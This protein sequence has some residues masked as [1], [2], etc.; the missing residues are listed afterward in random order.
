MKKAGHVLTSL[1]LLLIFGGSPLF[2]QIGIQPP[3]PPR[4]VQIFEPAT[5]PLG[6][7]IADSVFKNLRSKSFVR[8]VKLD[9][10]GQYVS[11]REAIDGREFRLPQVV[12]IETYIELRLRHDRQVQ[13]AQAFA[14]LIT[15]QVEQGFGALELEIPLRI[16]SQTFNRIFGSD[17]I[18]MRV[19]GNITFDLSGRTEKRSGSAVSALEDRGTFSP[20]FR[21]TQQFTVE[22]KIG[23]KVTVSVE[24]NSEAVS[25]V[26]NTLKLRYDG[27]EDEIVQ[28]IEAGNISLSLPSTKYVIFG[29]SN[30]GLFG[31]KAQMQMGNL[32]L[33]TIASLEKGQQEELTVNGSASEQTHTIKDYEFIRNRYFFIDL[34]YHGYFEQGFS[35]DLQQFNFRQGTD[36][37]FLD[38]YKTVYTTN[39]KVNSRFGIA[40]LDPQNYA[41]LTPSDMD[42]VIE[43]DGKTAKGYFRRLE[44]NVDYTFDKYRGF[45]AL[46]QSIGS[47]EVLAVAF[48]T[49]QDVARG[50]SVGTL[51]ASLA[52]SAQPVILK[53]IKPKNLQPNTT[54][55]ETW[56]LMMKN[57]YS[58]GG[59]NIEKD[60]FELKLEYN[61]TENHERFPA[62]GTKSFLNLTGL[63]VTDANGAP[64]D[65]GDD[66][67]DFN[68]YILNFAQ[69]VMIFPSLQPFNPGSAGKFGEFAA[70]DPKYLVNIYDESNETTIR[71]RSR[72]VMLVTS[73]STKSTFDLGFY[74]LEGS[75]VVTL[76]GQTLDRDKD[77]LIDYFSGQLTLLSPEAKRQSASL[78][79][80]YER[81]NLFQLDKKTIVG[82]RLEYR[83]WENSFVGMTG[84]YL[85]KTTLDERVRVGQEP[86][87]NFVWDLNGA[88][89]F[90]PRF[91]T[92]ALDA[93]PLIETNA[94]SQF[95]IE[96]E[97]AQVLP[98]PNTLNS[99]TTGDN[100]GVAY[101]DD[102]ESSKRTTTLGIRY[103]T[104]T[105]ASTPVKMSINGSDQKITDLEGDKTR[106]YLAWFNPYFQVPIK[107][108]W[109]NRDVNS[110]TGQTTEVLGLE[111]ARAA[112]SDPDS[113]W[114]GVMRTT[115][116]FADQQKTKYIEL[117]V[118]G[119][120]GRLNIDIGKI[121][122]DWWIKGEN[123]KNEPSRGNLNEEDFV[124]DNDLLDDGEDVGI[125]GIADGQ[126]GDDDKD[127]WGTPKE[128]AVNRYDGYDYSR[129]NG[130]EGNGDSRE[131][132][133][134]DTE[135]LDG[136][137]SLNV[138]NEYFE[139]SFSLDSLNAES[140]Q[141][142]A[143]ETEKGWRLFRIPLSDFTR[144]IGQPDTNFQQILA[145]RLW[146]SELPVDTTRIY[147]ATLD[148][149]G[150]EWE[151]KGFAANDSSAFILNDDVFSLATNNTEENAV[152]VEGLEPYTPPPGVSGTRDRITNTVSKEQSLV[153][154]FFDLPG[155][156]LAEGKKILLNTLDFLNY[157]R[158]RMFVHGDQQLP[159]AGTAD[160]TDLQFY[161]RFGSNDQNYYETGLDVFYGWAKENKI[162]VDLDELT[163]IKTRRDSSLVDFPNRPDDYFRYETGAGNRYFAI[164]GNPI[165]KA[166]RFII[167][168][169]RNKSSN[170][171]SGEVWLD[172]LRLSDI[173]KQS[174][175]ALR[176]KTNF[177]WADFIR[178]SAEWES[179]D[180]DF[181]N[182]STQFGGGNT[183]ETQ[184]Y[185]GSL[186]LDKLFPIKWDISMPLDAHA[187]FNRSIPKYQPKTDIL[188]GYE[189]NTIDKKLKSLFGLRQLDEELTPIIN[190][191]QVVGF[192]TT[193]NRRSKS[194]LWYLKYTIDQL[195]L[196]FDYSRKNSSSWELEYN[197][198]VNYRETIGYSIPF[199]ND[200]FFKPFG[201]MKSVPV[202][203]MMSDEKVYYA[204]ETFRLNLN[205]SDMTSSQKR[206]EAETVTT[207]LTT[208][209]T[210]AVSLSY[211][212]FDN[213]SANFNRTH[214]SDADVVGLKHEQLWKEILT[215][216]YF[217]KEIDISQ[218]FSGDY[219]FS[220]LTWLQPSLNY[221]S[222]FNYGLTNANK[223]KNATSRVS[224]RFGLTF[225]PA[226][227]L[228]N[229]G[230]DKAKTKSRPS[231]PSARQK[232]D[233]EKKDGTEEKPKISLPNPFTLLL[234]ALRDWQSIQTSYNIEQSV[235][236]RYLSGLPDWQFQFGL[237]QK[238]GVPQD[239]K[240]TEEGIV[241]ISPTFR[242][243]HALRTNTS[244]KF[245]KNISANLTHD[246]SKNEQTSD[247]GLSR[248]GQRSTNY[249]TLSETP[250]LEYKGLFNDYKSFVPDWTVQVSGL[251]KYLI[252]PS[253]ATSV[254][255][256][257]GHSGKYTESLQLSPAG[258]YEPRS[259]SF[260]NNWGPLVGVNI[261]TK[262]GVT[263]SARVTQNTTLNSTI[264]AGASRSETSSLTASLAFSKTTGFKIPIPVWPFK[265][266][267]FKNE[268]NFNL[269][270]DS[271]LNQV[272]QKQYT[273]TKFSEQTRNTAWKLRPSATYRFSKRV[274]GS[275]FLELGAT[276]NK[277]SG[278]Y[279]YTEFGINV[280]IAIKD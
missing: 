61:E 201:F 5:L 236:H 207:N 152:A 166:I 251:E 259:Q 41:A 170:P 266:K 250:H 164:R 219:K 179:Q 160:S 260:T 38:V 203:K 110:Q 273:A 104:W 3:P 277:I 263:G 216:M 12:S 271:S 279:S 127:N 247:G 94:E 113:A 163:R 198:T 117:W 43:R 66:L 98:N 135:D 265:G 31:L 111:F 52:D 137:Y 214:T 8:T 186:R 39:D 91:M 252:F 141:W 274:Q 147:I 224:K 79:I 118:Y 40:V 77:Y 174:A 136:D 65:N 249:L 182:I 14:K 76:N 67:I 13:F 128:N 168:G 223:Y 187:N 35:E 180:A 193:I 244:L 57:V 261:R 69:G 33:T 210:R 213:L 49:S 190:T 241:L 56:P 238:P 1:C 239:E 29:G 109:P 74:V 178:F 27:D 107:D 58:L 30:K 105:P 6:K 161:I 15:Q 145:T 47:N 90:K 243:N 134:P 112:E 256:D 272:F 157:K 248:S 181:H 92:R 175:T 121:S 82:G 88:L 253:F 84:L 255:L 225:K 64:L 129:V 54:Y 115:A 177:T 240:L 227:L 51:V 59:S 20:K 205:V 80:K 101:I 148:F 146:V 18:G 151:E 185:S 268:I 154:R 68:G 138:F 196:D 23:E 144:V 32:H 100:N 81:A 197:K 235:D 132:R 87:Q 242:E 269:T 62:G 126:P 48:A 234:T 176:V 21:Q 72:Y 86:F 37:Q 165:L 73:K 2:S 183:S 45:I 188:T 192:G 142:I 254:S 270:Y 83:F 208:G 159:V 70:L 226:D 89:K 99:P 229:I 162:E 139:Y 10:T 237:T 116:S 28:S 204:P 120:K 209:T 63:D 195:K 231:R 230:K 60:G 191:S 218:T 258:V 22:G 222:T 103:R 184:N 78:Q 16:K 228:K 125:D 25:E 189:N 46:N 202:L 264:G 149:V 245:G 75:D 50:S 9:S 167:V 171:F 155:G 140:R 206:R 71:D 95:D 199:G 194:N 276:E 102:F 280:N 262:W 114:G 96:G 131:A 130:T 267:T 150:N 172:E 158:M 36:V 93:L 211:K 85:N 108:I 156:H 246:F 44:Q 217:G 19:T 124:N 11:V 233:E 278:K 55:Q 7:I 4:L 200:N 257:H 97:F 17:R 153:M 232:E 26:E 53:L 123:Q 133:Y 220:A 106:A 221:N 215:K 169:V 143:G 42:T 122:E 212:L 24:Q 34:D 275:M 119:N 173:R